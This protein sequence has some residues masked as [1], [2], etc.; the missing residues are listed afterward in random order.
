MNFQ[1]VANK[2]IYISIY[3][4]H[5]LVYQSNIIQ[6]KHKVR[7]EYFTYKIIANKKSIFLLKKEK[8]PYISSII[9]ISGK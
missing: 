3:I 8:M 9:H 1:L 6:S 5:R 4:T 2:N 7:K